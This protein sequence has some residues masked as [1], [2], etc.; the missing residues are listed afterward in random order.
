MP[1]SGG[2]AIPNLSAHP[3]TGPT[4]YA[5]LDCYPEGQRRDVGAKQEDAR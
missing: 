1:A 2:I 4:A 3:E 5:L